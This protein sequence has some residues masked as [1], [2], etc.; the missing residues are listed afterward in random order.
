MFKFLLHP[1]KES[2]EPQHAAAPL[3]GT[4]WLRQIQKH[5]Q[6]SWEVYEE[7]KTPARFGR[8]WNFTFVNGRGISHLATPHPVNCAYVNTWKSECKVSVIVGRNW[9]MSTNLVK[10]LNIKFPKNSFNSSRVITCGQTDRHGGGNM[11]I[12]ATFSFERG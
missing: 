10:L 4:T 1:W 9:N 3:W 12:F 2:T 8:I 5:L 6:T 7:R 11:R